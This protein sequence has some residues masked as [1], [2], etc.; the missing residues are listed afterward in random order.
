MSNT[1]IWAIRPGVPSPHIVAAAVR[2]ARMIDHSGS[3]LADLARSYRQHTSGAYYPE[4]NMA[5]GQALLIDCG[6]VRQEGSR[7]IPTAELLALGLEDDVEAA[8]QLA[9]RAIA[10]LP[11]ETTSDQLQAAVEAAALSAEQ[12]EEFLLAL[13]RMEP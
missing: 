2:V 4:P 6:L 8:G 1:P 9:V 13:D 7:L 3:E 10:T 11:A 5:K 12:R